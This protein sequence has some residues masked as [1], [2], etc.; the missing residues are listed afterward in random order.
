MLRKERECSDP[1]FFNTLLQKAEV[2]TLAFHAEEYPYVLPVNFVFLDGNLYFHCA[3]KGYKLQCMQKNPRI[4]FSVYEV[5]EIDRE[6][7]TT[8][9]NSI[10]GQGLAEPVLNR[11]E[12]QAALSALAKKY[13]S[14]CKL[15]VQ[16]N[17]LEKTAVIRISITVLSGKRNP[18]V[19][20]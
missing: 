12:K 8:R 20:A 19:S 9:Y 7:A 10:C 5:L 15:P 14:N 3:Q 1:I 13:R 18:P 11:E 6:H 16:G 2:M 4:G 17:M